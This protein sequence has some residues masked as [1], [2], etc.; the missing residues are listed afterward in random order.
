MKI[1]FE[2]LTISIH[3]PHTRDDTEI[4]DDPRVALLFQST[5]L[6]RGTTSVLHAPTKLL[7][8]SIHVPHT[9]DDLAPAFAGLRFCSISIHVP[10]TRDDFQHFIE[11]SVDVDF[12]PRPSHEGRPLQMMMAMA[13]DNFNPRPSHEGRRATSTVMQSPSYFNPRPSHEGRLFFQAVEDGRIVISI[14]VPHTRDDLCYIKELTT[15]QTFQST[16]LTRGTTLISFSFACLNFQFQ[17]TSL[18]RGTTSALS[19]LSPSPRDFNPR[20]SHE[21]RPFC[22][23]HNKL[24]VMVFQSTSL[25]RG[26]TGGAVSMHKGEIFQSTSLTR[27][28][29]SKRVR[30]CGIDRFQ[31]TSLTRG[32]TRWVVHT[33]DIHTISIHVPHT[34]DDA[35][36][37]LMLMFQIRFQSTSL[38]RGTTSWIVKGG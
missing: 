28:T 36:L 4:K 14:H 32:T 35:G 6:T 25:T 30:L 9:R 21:G 33:V 11:L 5:S 8:I 10:H 26:T 17:S 23:H 18:T 38:T 2:R 1:K 15:W 37:V 34:R 20:P 16:S 12:N 24:T 3:V 13:R 27:G 31:S 22:I 29:T 7:E 19:T